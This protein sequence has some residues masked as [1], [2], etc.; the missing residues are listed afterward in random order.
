M[1]N[2]GVTFVKLCGSIGK[3]KRAHDQ[4]LGGRGNGALL[5]FSAF[6]SRISTFQFIEVKSTSFKV[7]CKN[8]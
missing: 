6:I 5:F 2:D 3:D 8:A 4:K 7:T 1:N